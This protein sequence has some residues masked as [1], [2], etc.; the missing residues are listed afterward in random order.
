MTGAHPVRV[1]WWCGSCSLSGEVVQRESVCRGS[2]EVRTSRRSAGTA[3]RS[4]SLWETLEEKW[5]L[6]GQDPLNLARLRDLS[7]AKENIDSY[8]QCASL[9]MI[10]VFS[11]FPAVLSWTPP[12]KVFFFFPSSVCLYLIF[13]SCPCRILSSL[14]LGICHLPRADGHHCGLQSSSAWIPRWPSAGVILKSLLPRW[15]REVSNSLSN[16]YIE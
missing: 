2:T 9:L 5:R 11:Y 3:V 10:K 4:E 15:H 8:K 7:V 1:W 16:K 6:C 14:G 13:P 12:K